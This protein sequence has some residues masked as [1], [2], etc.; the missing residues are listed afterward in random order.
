MRL[1]EKPKCER[2]SLLRSCVGAL[3]PCKDLVPTQEHGN[4]MDNLGFIDN[5]VTAIDKLGILL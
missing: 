4:Q 1:S 5:R 2:L 3:C